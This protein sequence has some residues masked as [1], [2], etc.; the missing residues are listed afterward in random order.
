MAQWQAAPAPDAQ[1]GIAA[2]GGSRGL[3]TFQCPLKRVL[4]DAVPCVWPRRH[5]HWDTDGLPRYIVVAYIVMAKKTSSL[6]HRWPAEV[7][8]YGP[9]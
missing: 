5:R 3:H 6:G 2:A 4:Y 9:I 1:E 8:S 7:Y